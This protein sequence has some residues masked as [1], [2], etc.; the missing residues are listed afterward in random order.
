VSDKVA[1]ERQDR[2]LRAAVASRIS[3]P[4][5]L[6][7]AAGGAGP[8][9][10]GG[11]GSGAMLKGNMSLPGRHREALTLRAKLSVV[12]A[13]L[14]GFG[15]TANSTERRRFVDCAVRD[16]VS[17]YFPEDDLPIAAEC[18]LFECVLDFE[19]VALVP[20]VELDPRTLKKIENAGLPKKFEELNVY[21][22]LRQ[23]QRASKLTFGA[24]DRLVVRTQSTRAVDAVM[25]RLI[26]TGANTLLFGAKGCGKSMLISD[27]L[28][29]L[30]SNISTPQAMREQVNQHLVGI[31]N[32][33][34]KADG[35]FATMEILKYIMG[36]FASMELKDDNETQFSELW[37]TAGQGLKVFY[38]I[39]F[40]FI[41]FIYLFIYL[42]ILIFPL[43]LS[44]ALF[45]NF[46][47][48]LFILFYANI[49]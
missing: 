21:V 25:R 18:S 7:P 19:A 5:A 33:V 15:G 8:G 43:Y 49:L 26:S 16:A 10:G 40:Y 12:Y 24:Q 13:A 44:F 2:D 38:F 11:A 48:A 47:C 35:I 30:K 23:Q 41:L 36:K 27:I 3:M 34:S 45:W 14:W 6:Q 32:G 22:S 28:D 46:F 29:D 31:T 20:A 42:F 37:N 1:Q 39:L 17:T 9:G 4:S